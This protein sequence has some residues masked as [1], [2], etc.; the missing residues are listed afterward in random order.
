MARTRSTTCDHCGR[1]YVAQRIT[2]RF[3][4]DNCRINHHREMKSYNPQ[5][6]LQAVLWELNKL[7][8]MTERK[9]DTLLDV[10]ETLQTIQNKIH[11]INTN[12]YPRVLRYQNE[13]REAELQ[14]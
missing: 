4:S 14:D 12:L 6:N 11:E 10:D 2:S 9:P 8:K 5:Q 7:V 1:Q 3:C 13:L